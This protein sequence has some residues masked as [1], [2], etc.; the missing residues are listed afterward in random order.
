VSRSKVDVRR[1]HEP[2]HALGCLPFLAGGQGRPSPA[3]SRSSPPTALAPGRVSRRRS[4]GAGRPRD[5][6]AIRAPPSL[7]SRHAESRGPL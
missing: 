1:V 4:G 6:D 2:K 5:P 3:G 7:P